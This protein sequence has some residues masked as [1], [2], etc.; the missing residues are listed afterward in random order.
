MQPRMRWPRLLTI[1]S[2]PCNMRD[3]LPPPGG[4]RSSPIVGEHYSHGFHPFSRS[5]GGAAVPVFWRPGG[6]RPPALPRQGAS[7]HRRRELRARLPGAD[8]HP[9]AAHHLPARPAHRRPLRPGPLGLGAGR[10]LPGGTHAVRPCLRAGSCVTRTGLHH[11]HGRQRPAAAHRAARHP[12][13]TASAAGPASASA[14]GR[15]P[16][17]GFPWSAACRHRRSNWRRP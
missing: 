10:C 6:A 17:P 4:N 16:L 2:L 15:C 3:M 13:R 7:R 12:V 11:C 14:A 5:A 9:G 8:E 1:I